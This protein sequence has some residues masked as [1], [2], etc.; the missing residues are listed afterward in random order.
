SFEIMKEPE[1]PYSEPVESGKPEKKLD[2]VELLLY[3]LFA[4]PMALIGLIFLLVFTCAGGVFL[5]G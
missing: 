4:V 1:N 3:W 5:F 2:I